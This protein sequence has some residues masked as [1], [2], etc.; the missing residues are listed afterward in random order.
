M[1]AQVRGE[2]FCGDRELIYVY[3]GSIAVLFDS[4]LRRRDMEERTYNAT[5]RNRKATEDPA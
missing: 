4:Q 5:K 3:A 1:S 2:D